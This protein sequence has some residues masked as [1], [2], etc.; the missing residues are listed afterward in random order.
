MTLPVTRSCFITLT[1]ISNGLLTFPNYLNEKAYDFGRLH[2]RSPQKILTVHPVPLRFFPA[3]RLRIRHKIIHFFLLT[4][5]GKVNRLTSTVPRHSEIH[6]YLARK[7]CKDLGIKS[8][9]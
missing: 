1:L 8:V 5:L 2:S 7:I 6:D 4:Q 9:H 3:P